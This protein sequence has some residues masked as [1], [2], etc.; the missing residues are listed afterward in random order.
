[1]TDEN[2]NFFKGLQEG[3]KDNDQS[4]EEVVEGLL[5]L[6]SEIEDIKGKLEDLQMQ[7][8]V[9]YSLILYKLG[10]SNEDN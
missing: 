10:E 8:I 9:L 5:S 4:I 6:E 7:R 1:M 3:F 2:L